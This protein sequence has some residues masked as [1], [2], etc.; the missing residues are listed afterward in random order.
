[1]R[2][3]FLLTDI[4][5]MMSV[6]AA[7]ISHNP[8][9]SL[10]QKC[11]YRPPLHVRDEVLK[12]SR[13]WKQTNHSQLWGSGRVVKM[14]QWSWYVKAEGAQRAVYFQLLLYPSRPAL[15]AATLKAALVGIDNSDQTA[16]HQ[17]KP[18]LNKLSSQGVKSEAAQLM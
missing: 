1:M 10:V 6:T 14:F 17:T 2:K 11:H 8:I 13:S 9:V 15:S 12:V 3:M 4:M 18:P 5:S 16:S 7:P